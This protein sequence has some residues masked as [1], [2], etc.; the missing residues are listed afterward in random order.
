M[1]EHINAPFSAYEVEKLN[2]YQQN[3]KYHPFTCSSSDRSKCLHEGKLEATVDGWVCPCGE[4]KQ[5]WA[6]KF[7]IE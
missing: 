6:H 2:K 1:N 5:N 4:Y 3:P 7:M